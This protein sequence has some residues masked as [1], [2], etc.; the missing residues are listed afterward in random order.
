[1]NKQV[2]YT[3]SQPLTFKPSKYA[4]FMMAAKV[5]TPKYKFYVEMG[6]NPNHPTIL[7]ISG[8]GAQ[9]LMWP[10]NFCKL[11]IDAGF[12]VIR[13]DNRDIGK[14]TKIKKKR[15]KNPEPITA[16]K[17]LSIAGRFK[18]G[19]S[20]RNQNVPY[21]LFDMAAD[22]RYILDA[23]A[24]QQTYIIGSSM[25]GMIA[26]ILAAKY[27]ERILGL[28]LLST[29]SNR[30]M[31]TPPFPRQMMSFMNRTKQETEDDVIASMV[32]VLERIGSPE[33]FDRD[34][35]EKFAR[36]LYRRKFYPKGALRQLTA[37]LATGSLVI[38]NKRIVCPTI[39]VHGQKDRVFLPSHGR[40]L[41]KSIKGARF[42]MIKGMGHDIPQPLHKEL[43]QCFVNHFLT[44]PTGTKQVNPI[45]L[46]SL[47]YQLETL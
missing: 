27:P 43:V 2:T 39:V 9:M 33:H 24:I 32:N 36:T 21:N 14:S 34:E 31:S 22:T 13:F 16:L 42:Q 8:L 17:R 6:G 25:G 18:L 29:S 45:G 26:Q 19:L 11:L 38:T 30:P 28:G 47:G 35:A 44:L 4:P 23:L 3:S 5:R 41:A 37:V 10:T 7:L 46:E 12:Q 15:Q 1:M 40:A 20:N